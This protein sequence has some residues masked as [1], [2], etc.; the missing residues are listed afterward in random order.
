GGA[1]PD[2]SLHDAGHGEAPAEGAA[3][4]GNRGRR[5]G[6]QCGMAQH[7]GV[8][9]SPTLVVVGNPGCRRVAFW[10]AAAELLGWPP[11]RLVAYADLLLGRTTLA[12]HVRP[13]DV[14]RYETAADQWE[15]FK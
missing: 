4:Q 3:V 6:P 5:P 15:T 14:L 8:R 1:E 10:G 7:C 12:D 13:G 2:P 9:M 11:M